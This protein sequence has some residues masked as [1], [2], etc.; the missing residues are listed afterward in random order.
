VTTSYDIDVQAARRRIAHSIRRTPTFSVRFDNRDILLK[1]EHL[2]VGGSFKF[3]GASN[4]VANLP[5][6]VV[7]VITASGGNHGLAV[8]LAA[9]QAGVEATIVVPDTAPEEKM[10]RIR[11]TGAKLIVHGHEYADAEAHAR[12]MAGDET[13]FLHPFADADV[14]A[15]Q[16]TLGLEI[17]DE[18]GDQCDA[19]VVAV[20]GGGLVS[21]V[22][23]AL[24]DTTLRAFGV[25]PAGIPTMRAALDAGAP[26]DVEVQSVTASSLGARRTEPINLDIVRRLVADIA[27]VNDD[28]IVDAQQRLW[29][30][31]R[32]AV[33]PGAA[34]ALAGV[35]DGLIDTERPCVVLCGANSNWQRV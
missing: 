5:P 3:R 6:G 8:A 26:V 21:G 14:I 20:G 22:A 29:D 4:A 33:E 24:E 17:A 19:V 28:R 11:T 30:E 12:S 27:L 10:Q 1:L 35:L 9:R 32:L 7:R 25:E 16:G 23:C 13:R 18:V 15:G 31:C 34:V 2:Q